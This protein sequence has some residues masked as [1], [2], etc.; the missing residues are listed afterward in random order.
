MNSSF[1]YERSS[2]LNSCWLKDVDTSEVKR[3]L[4]TI[5]IER[6]S[7]YKLNQYH[8]H[9]YTQPRGGFPTYEKQ[10]ALM[11]SLYE[12]G[13]DF[14]PLTIDSNTRQNDYVRAQQ[15][16]EKSEE[17]NK[18][19]LNG[20]PL[21]NHGFALTR[22][23]CNSVNAP[24]SLRHG[25]PDARILVEAAIAAGVTEIEGGGICYTIPYS[26]KYPLDQALLHW[27]YVDEVCAYYSTESRLIH[28]ESFG[29]LTA[30]MIPP[31]ITCAVQI[32]EL[33]LAAEKGVKSFSVSFGQTGSFDQDVAIG[34]VLPKLANQFLEMF[35][36]DDVQVKLVYHQ[37][38]GAF[39]YDQSNSMSL[40][41]LSALIAKMIRADKVVVK[42]K[43]EA[44]GIPAIESNSEAIKNVK[45]LFEVSNISSLF[46]NEMIEEECSHIKSQVDYLL[47]RVLSI[48]TGCLWQSV[49]L[50]FQKGMIDIP[51]APHELNAN[52]LITLR[53]S[54]GAIRVYKEGSVPVSSRDL[55][56]ERSRLVKSKADSGISSKILK[57]IN[58]ML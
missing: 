14:I 30:T 5:D 32:L 9:P 4:S 55:D 22:K 19:F 40:I 48:K 17:C 39:P 38:M 33:L 41:S 21:V 26:K 29:P 2:L 42:T 51:F 13:A 1:E 57:D 7:S 11:R 31:F 15:F 12:A 24:I 20:Y 35:G 45:Y 36:F 16:L 10:L 54:H 52:S 8:K 25:T 56:Y 3:Y 50:A 28:R 53:D 46:S 47:E 18:D 49:F 6:F 58:V 37:W 34:L 23:L 27:M 43:E 44:F